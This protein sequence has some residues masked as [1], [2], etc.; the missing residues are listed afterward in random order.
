MQN[1]TLPSE[2]EV[3]G[4]YKIKQTKRSGTIAQITDYAILNGGFSSNKGNLVNM[5]RYFLNDLY[6]RAFFSAYIVSY[7]D[8]FGQ[9]QA[10]EEANGIGIRPV[11][12]Y[13]DVLAN[14]PDL[15]PIRID[16]NLS[17]V[18]YGKILQSAVDSELQVKLTNVKALKELILT[19]EQKE[20]LK[21]FLQL[22]EITI[23]D[24][25]YI[26]NTKNYSSF[27]AQ[28]IPVYEYQ[29]RRFAKVKANTC[30]SNDENFT[31]SNGVSYKNGDDIWIEEEPVKWIINEKN[32]TMISKK[33]IQAG[34]RYDREN[35]FFEEPNFF[36]TELNYYLN[37]YLSK[38]LFR[39]EK[40]LTKRK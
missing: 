6:K 27:F 7:V 18:S 34:V 14:N 12:E 23:T 33:I 37:N 32:D 15:R 22:D 31:L 1:L 4:D 35:Y 2:V 13:S 9:K 36:R 19:G 30:F 17:E 5:G 21:D 38:E 11:L 10:S 26:R 28:T 3:F 25:V 40:T 8:E 20:H 24:D 29:G 16:S 39:S